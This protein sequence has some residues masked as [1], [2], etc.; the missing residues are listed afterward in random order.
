MIQDVENPLSMFEKESGSDWTEDYE[1]LLRNIL[2]NASLMSEHHKEEHLKY[3]RRLKW[4]KLPIIIASGVNS[5]ISVSL[6]Q[7]IEQSYVSVINCLVSLTISIIG[8]I[9]L[10][11]MINKKADQEA[12]AYK[13]FY[14][15]ALKINN[16]LKLKRE[17][18]GEEPKIFLNCVISEY[19][20]AFNEATINGLSTNDKLI[21]LQLTR[22]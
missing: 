18:R 22:T 16:M 17:H 10:F 13:E 14:S 19:L 6:N 8:S 11:L 9:E 20:T 3:D 7:Y 12:V 2:F 1:T 5:I 21:D 4:Y 15:L